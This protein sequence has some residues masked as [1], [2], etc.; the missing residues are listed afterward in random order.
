MPA[1]VLESW[2]QVVQGWVWLDPLP[3]HLQEGEGGINLRSTSYSSFCVPAGVTP[4]KLGVAEMAGVP[5]LGVFSRGVCPPIKRWLEGLS[6]QRDFFLLPPCGVGV[7]VTDSLWGVSTHPVWL[8]VPPGRGAIEE[9][10]LMLIKSSFQYRNQPEGFLPISGLGPSDCVSP[11]LQG[12]RDRAWYA[13]EWHPTSAWWRAWHWHRE[14][15]S[16]WHGLESHPN[17]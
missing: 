8:G 12:S 17:D 16:P 11:G 6:S 1:S 15:H 10:Q 2:S 3:R 13:L 4:E 14:S 7:S 9:N 5:K